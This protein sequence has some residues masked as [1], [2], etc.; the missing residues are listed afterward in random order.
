VITS[1]QRKGGGPLVVIVV[2]FLILI[3]LSIVLYAWASALA[4]PY[5][6]SGNVDTRALDAKYYDNM[7]DWE[8]DN[9]DGT[10]ELSNQE[11]IED[12]EITSIHADYNWP[13]AEIEYESNSDEWSSMEI[14]VRME[15]VGNVW[16]IQIEGVTMDGSYVQ[17]PSDECYASVHE[18]RYYGINS[19]RGAVTETEWPY[20]CDSVEGY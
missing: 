19:W 18:D 13:Y 10:V 17:Y 2:I 1:T 5:T 4:S 7:G 20:W 9:S 15:I 12:E 6:W 8:R 14:D 3:V 16:F 11:F